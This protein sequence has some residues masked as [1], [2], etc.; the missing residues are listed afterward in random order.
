VY[1]DAMTRG[2]ALPGTHILAV[3]VGYEVWNGPVTNLK[4]DDFYVDVH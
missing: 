2:Y 1:H 4:T 3:A